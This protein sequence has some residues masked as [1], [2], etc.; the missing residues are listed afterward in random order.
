MEMMGY[1][2]HDMHN[3][4]FSHSFS[5]ILCGVAFSN[6][7]SVND[8]IGRNDLCIISPGA[9]KEPCRLCHMVQY[10]LLQAVRTTSH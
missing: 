5:L 2:M 10:G 6:V 9:G 4:S 3:C 7:H 8:H 1:I